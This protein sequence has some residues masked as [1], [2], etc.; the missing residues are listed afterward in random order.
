[1]EKAKELNI[2]I[3]KLQI[4]KEKAIQ[5]L[6]YIEN[7]Y[8]QLSWTTQFGKVFKTYLT[9]SGIAIKINYQHEQENLMQIE[10]ISYENNFKIVEQEILSYLNIKEAA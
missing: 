9:P 8:K 10:L 6:N 4:T 7:K 2:D 3:S 5:L 1:M